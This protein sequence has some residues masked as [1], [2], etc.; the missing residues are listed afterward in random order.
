[1]PLSTYT[2]KGK[3]GLSNE[4]GVILTKA[5][6]D[7]IIVLDDVVFCRI[8]DDSIYK[9]HFLDH[10]GDLTADLSKT[11]FPPYNDLV[12][13]GYPLDSE[14]IQI[15]TKDN[16]SGIIDFEGMLIIEPQ[17]MNYK[18]L[19]NGLILA[20]PNQEND[21]PKDMKSRVYKRN[22]ELL[23]EYPLSIYQDFSTSGNILFEFK[24]G[25]QA[26]SFL[27]SPEGEVL[28]KTTL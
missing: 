16:T 6:Y 10:S 3:K 4:S 18:L 14:L 23:S 27:T 13:F 17:R 21:N 25:E 1:M 12:E 20:D 8:N 11:L 22:G 2:H 19:S 26:E 28:S 24:E 9:S 5:I 15:S 7:V